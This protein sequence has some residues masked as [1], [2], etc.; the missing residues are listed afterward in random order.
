MLINGL[1]EVSVLNI[2]MLALGR[3]PLNGPTWTLSLI[4][5]VECIMYCLEWYSKRLFEEVILPIS[6]VLAGIVYMRY[7]VSAT[8]DNLFRI[9]ACRIWIDI[10]LGL[11][12]LNVSHHFQ[13]A[14]GKK[15]RIKITI[16]EIICHLGFL[17]LACSKTSNYYWPDLMILSIM[18]S[19]VHSQASYLEVLLKKIRITPCLATLSLG[20]YLTHMSVYVCYRNKYPEP[21]E[22][23]AHKLDFLVMVF[24]VAVSYNI[25]MNLILKRRN[26]TGVKCITQGERELMR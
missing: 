20:I 10:S 6:F 16:I 17:F 4:F 24:A 15:I 2:S 21:N 7:D 23:Y 18:L 1:S 3:W 9:E 25:L 22:M 19:I 13:I 14:F 11:L 5:L 8:G 12:C 26:W